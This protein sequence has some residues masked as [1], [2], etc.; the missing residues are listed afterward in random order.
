ME[1]LQGSCS[2]AAAMT[3]RL[4]R[5][6]GGAT[7]SYW[8]SVTLEREA[9]GTEKQVFFAYR[10]PEVQTIE[11]IK[12]ALVIN[13]DGFSQ[14]IEKKDFQRLRDEPMQFWSGKQESRYIQPSRLL[15]FGAAGAVA[16]SGVGALFLAS[17]RHRR[18]AKHKVP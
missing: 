14:R 1:E 9:L 12:D 15:A 13:G 8:Y 2:P 6:N 5:G 11:C 16:L 10:S 4:Y 7:T 3:A 18:Q 17:V